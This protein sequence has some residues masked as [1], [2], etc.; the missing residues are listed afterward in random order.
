MANPALIS[1]GPGGRFAR[2]ENNGDTRSFKNTKLNWRA[3][4]RR[5]W[6]YLGKKRFLLVL[7][8]LFSISSSVLALY[9]PKLS[10]AA[11]NTIWNSASRSAVSLRFIWFILFSPSFLLH[12]PLFTGYPAFAIRTTRRHV[13]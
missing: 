2:G 5:L 10:G 11:I 12:S 4:L 1:G 3:I 6:T 8:V 13:L 9:S 7:A